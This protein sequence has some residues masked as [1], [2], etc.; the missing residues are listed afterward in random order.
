MSTLCKFSVLRY[1]PNETREEFI[2]IGLVF[3]CPSEGFIDFRYTSNFSRVKKFD[4][5]VDIEFLK[6]VLMGVENEFTQ[7]T[8]H[9][10]S[11]KHISDENFL[12]K[13]TNFYSNQLQFSNTRMIRSNNPLRDFE[14]LFKTYVYFDAKK[15]K[16]ISEQEVKTIMNRVLKKSI[17]TNKVSKNYTIDVGSEDITLD[18]SY[19]SK[20]NLRKKYI[21]TLS[22]DYSPKK[23]KMATQVAKEWAWNFSKI[24]QINNNSQIKNDL[25]TVVYFNKPDKNIEIALNILGENSK[26]FSANNEDKIKEFAD[27]IL[28]DVKE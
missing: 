9:G 8:D 24:E 26:L 10:P 5:E 18:F 12:E 4:D 19:E 14:N 28:E 25:L 15:N 17:S 16:R 7:G 13:N 2:N 20:E 11:L 22:F 27:E 21:K 6:L 3:H 1:I 23:T